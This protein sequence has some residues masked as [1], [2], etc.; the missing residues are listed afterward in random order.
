MTPDTPTLWIVPRWG[1]SADHDFYPWLRGQLSA[2]GV[3][4]EGLALDDPP[5]I[6]AAIERLAPRLATAADSTL[7][8]GHSVGVQAV[9][10][11]LATTRRERPLAGLVAV[12]GWFAVDRPWPTIVPWIETPIDHAR[13]R[14]AVREV[15]VLVS[16]DDP[17]TADFAT[18]RHQFEDR[19]GARVEVVPGA[20]H[21]NAAEEPAVLRTVRALL[22]V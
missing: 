3:A 10:R 11:A 20:A 2:L 15:H 19:L 18:T 17:F 5:T 1:G 9:L 14:A 16:D 13:A 4:V 21:F 6:E 7:L 12:A 22:D 8:L